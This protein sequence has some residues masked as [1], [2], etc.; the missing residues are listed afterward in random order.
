MEKYKLT[1]ETK[2]YNGRILHRI[3]ALIEFAD[4]EAGDLGGW[5]E[6]EHNLSHEGDCWVYDE[7]IV[8]KNATVYGNA[9]ICDK[10][11]VCDN[12]KVFQNS[13]VHDNSVIFDYANTFGNSVIQ[14][15]AW[16]GGNASVYGNSNVFGLA[17]VYGNARV[18]DYCSIS[19]NSN[20]L[21]EAK[22]FSNAKVKGDAFVGLK[23]K[24][25]K[26]ANI[27]RVRDFVFVSPVFEKSNDVTFYRTDEG[28]YILTN[29]FNMTLEEFQTK[30]DDY[31][32]NEAFLQQ[33]E[34]AIQLAKTIIN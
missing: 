15:C 32:G 31:K 9:I 25:G 16:I 33:Y 20:I 11:I 34:A 30:L 23:I 6:G 1:E 14:D 4:V 5:V 26:D 10:S 24:L 3:Q 8:M 18:Y 17:R 28:I 22:I 27:K 19:G 29:E 7:A 13:H 21:D 12:A 2:K